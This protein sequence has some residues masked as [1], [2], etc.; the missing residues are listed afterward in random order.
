MC[1]AMYKPQVACVLMDGGLAWL[2]FEFNCSPPHVAIHTSISSRPEGRCFGQT[3]IE[4]RQWTLRCV[5]GYNAT[6]QAPEQTLPSVPY[7][8]PKAAD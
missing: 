4:R 3:S 5:P 8:H 1:R 2:A 7:H 6:K